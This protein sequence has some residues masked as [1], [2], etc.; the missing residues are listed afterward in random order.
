M[1]DL[2]FLRAG[3]ADVGALVD[4]RIDFMRIVKD[5]GL[6]DEAEWRAEL[7][8]RFSRD[9]GSG[10][11][12]AWICAAGD[13]SPGPRRV[14]ATSGLAYPRDG[15]M[16]RELGL[17]PGEALL[18]NMYTRPEHRRRGL[19][20]ELL[21]RSIA[22]ARALGA[23]AIRLQGTADSRRLY[24][25]RGFVPACALGETEMGE[26]MLLGLEL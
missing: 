20:S 11:L 22:E 21:E 25:R 10:D 7:G 15:E 17:G 3:Q 1:S 16:R 24:G 23:R 13:L 12:V 18:C 2:E 14:L 5:G 9:L 4:L 8:E 26:D 19:A 6:P